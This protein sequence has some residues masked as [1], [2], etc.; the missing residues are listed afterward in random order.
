VGQRNE[1]SVFR[2]WQFSHNPPLSRS[3]T[4]NHVHTP[5]QAE[6]DDALRRLAKC[7]SDLN[8]A[9]S[10]LRAA[11]DKVGLTSGG[12]RQLGDSDARVKVT[13]L[14]LQ[15]AA[16]SFERKNRAL[17]CHRSDAQFPTR[18]SR[19]PSPTQIRSLEAP[20]QTQPTD[21]LAALRKRVAEDG[22]AAVRAL[23]AEDAAALQRDVREQEILLQS[24]QRENERLAAQLKDLQ[25]GADRIAS[26]WQSADTLVR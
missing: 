20:A 11:E 25:V 16:P 2:L 19:E 4:H 14:T 9:Q 7:E 18:S 23:S 3:R 12:L 8:E 17:R 13:S 5:S 1:S 26:Q 21:T 24:F 15:G 6:H 22:A 10:L